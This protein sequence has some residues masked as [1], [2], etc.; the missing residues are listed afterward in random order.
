LPSLYID[1]F[2][3]SQSLRRRISGAF[4][5]A[6]WNLTEDIEAADVAFLDSSVISEAGLAVIRETSARSLL[7]M[8]GAGDPAFA[9]GLVL[10]ADGV[11]DRDDPED[12]WLRAAHELMSGFGWISPPL[13]SRFR[14]VSAPVP[15]PAPVTVTSGQDTWRRVLSSA[16]YDIAQLA[17]RGLSNAEIA[18]ERWVREGTIK[19]Q[20]SSVYRKL[21]L[22]G[23]SALISLGYRRRRRP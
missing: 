20:L 1:G 18:E 13:V 5:R 15:G 16:E 21:G 14:A 8:W 9:G 12:D 23:R 22:R 7:M 17:V 19:Q 3:D 2:A 10:Q 6:A 4:A 11:V